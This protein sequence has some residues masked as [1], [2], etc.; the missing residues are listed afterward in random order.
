[1]KRILLST[2]R[3]AAALLLFS[4]LFGASAQNL[5]KPDASRIFD[6]F[7]R[8]PLSF[9]VNHGQVDPQVR[10][11]TRGDGYSLF[12]TDREA[13][14]SLNKDR[15]ATP[16]GGL[17]S[18][19]SLHAYAERDEIAPNV[20]RM[21]LVGGR[22]GEQISGLDRLPGDVNYFIGKDASKW[23]RGLPT[24][25]KVKYAGVYPGIDLVYYGN[26]RRLEYDFVVTP[27]AD[28]QAIRLGFAGA[29][30]LSLTAGGDLRIAVPH[31]E[32][33]LQRPVVYQ[34][35]NGSRHSIRGKFLLLAE[36]QVGFKIAS[37][38]RS[39]PLV[40][41]P[42]LTYATYIGGSD[43]FDYATGI[44]VDNSGYMYVTGVAGSTNFPT[45][46][47]S[48]Q[49]GNSYG[50]TEAFVAKLNSTGSEAA[51]VTYL[52]AS[53]GA[54]ATG[55]SIDGS[56]NAYVTGSTGSG[57]FPV[58]TG[59][60]QTEVPFEATV[61]FVSKL[62]PDGDNLVYSTF[63]AAT[64]ESR[65][66]CAAIVVDG[67]G[68]A[69]VTGRTNSSS[70]PTTTGTYQSTDIGAS[71]GVTNAFAT[72]FS[73]DGTSL[74]YSTY[75]GGTTGSTYGTAI[76]LDANDDAYLTGYTQASDFPVSQ[77]AFQFTLTGGQAAFVTAFN[78]SGSSLI[79]ST[80]LGGTSSDSGYGI[81]VDQD[82]N[83][84][85]TGQ[86]GSSDFPITTGV[87]QPTIGGGSD[88]FVTKVNPTG[89]QLVYSSFLGG[90]SSDYGA[91]IAVDSLGEA[92]VTGYTTSSNFPLTT[93]ALGKYAPS[94]HAAFV[95]KVNSTA[96][97]LLYS[98]YLGGSNWESASAIVLDASGNAYV[99]GQA[100]SSDF[101]VTTG[102]FQTVNKGPTNGYSNGF[103]AEFVIGGETNISLTSSTNPQL[104]NFPVTFTA[105]VSANFSDQVPTGSVVFTID[106]GTG[107]TVALDDTGKATYT[108]SSLSPK[109]GGHT[110][111]VSYSGDSNFLASNASLTQTIV[112]APAT[113][114]VVS[115]TGQSGTTGSGSYGSFFAKPLTAIVKDACSNPVFNTSVTF[116]GTG[117]TLSATQSATQT[118]P[119]L[120][121]L[122][123]NTGSNGEASVYAYAATSGAISVTAAVAGVTMPASFTLN[124]A[125]AKLTFTANNATATYDQPLP[126]FFFTING[127]VNGDGPSVLSGAPTLSTTATVGSPVGKYPIVV[128]PGTLAAA[129]YTF[130]F[131][132]GTLTINPEP[133]TITYHPQ[134]PATVIWGQPPIT[135][136]A[137]STCHLPVTFSVASGPG[138]V[139]GDM[140]SITGTGTIT[141]AANQAGNTNCLK[142]T[143]AYA[144]INVKHKGQ[145][146]TLTA[147]PTIYTWPVKNLI[148]LKAK[149][150]SGLP[151]TLRVVS[152]PAILVG[153][154]LKII[155]TGTVVVE[156]KQ[157]GNSDYLAS[158]TTLTILIKK[159]TQ[160]IAF[161]MPD[162]AV[163]GEKLPLD[164][165]V[166]SHLPLRFSV[167]SGPGKI[168]GNELKFIGVGQV[169]IAASNAGNTDWQKAEATHTF[170]VTK[171]KLKVIA[172]GFASRDGQPL[173]TYSDYR[174]GFVNG[175]PRG[176]ASPGR[177]S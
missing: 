144:Y 103:A 16:G 17:R 164:A 99:D 76:A 175:N 31:G 32:I 10:Y 20:I 87:F 158:S 170:T 75:L 55:I 92:Y 41:D 21:Q 136:S 45:T 44:A 109:C 140:L 161:H 141:I 102:A 14:L 117:A 82:D 127:L 72:E 107:I 162:S 150:T 71:N 97:E 94:G 86:A 168:I 36:N 77:G 131:V 51:Y 114:A 96:T 142:A 166:D 46:Q 95:S 160:H 62:N 119:G 111:G 137:Y 146:V 88:A 125:Q 47:G 73:A 138:V 172:N 23:R 70:F 39:Q 174:A 56:G 74:V 133:Q 2:L 116:T 15:G 79:Y 37:Y 105:T 132:D 42:I 28:P 3:C 148:P 173:P 176:A 27:G 115:G 26:Q 48:L 163:N 83:A 156:A 177:R 50:V 84:Y 159:G 126:Q 85:I 18:R 64:K 13:V 24:Y 7:A 1:M 67:S 59:A 25:E 12:L 110:I 6:A 151:V 128:G 80:F 29:E 11:F 78:S 167:V 130:A 108:T 5:D 124:A 43:G 113:I 157:S 106:G 120:T 91:S 52:G 135:L 154:D 65:T 139:N 66:N 104:Q 4:C 112:G 54:S 8:L 152:G 9:E 169:V 143:T 101:P 147:S 149:A 129:N 61:G 58:T 153:D 40:I 171:A 19:D 30:K 49:T 165:T 34:M 90:R 145:T 33:E 155:G 122:Q 134:P 63:L 89:T 93:S 118:N 35:L 53:G 69:F 121:S 38:D 57:D 100:Y 22:S 123:V 60:F 81:A 98:T 68:H